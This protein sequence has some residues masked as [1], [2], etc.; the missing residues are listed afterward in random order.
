MPTVSKRDGRTEEFMPEKIV[1]SAVK[2]GASPESAREIAGEVERSAGAT[3]STQEI[4][5]RV[6][7]GLERRNPEWRRNWEVYDQAVKRRG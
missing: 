5:S 2:S 1:V 4:R 3:I 7:G 6:L